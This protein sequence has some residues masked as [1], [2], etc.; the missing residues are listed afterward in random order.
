MWMKIKK[1]LTANIGFKILAL[2]FSIALWMIVVNVD[3]MCIR[4]SSTSP[5]AA[6]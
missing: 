6:C 2:V 1:A 4:D 3:E 5:P